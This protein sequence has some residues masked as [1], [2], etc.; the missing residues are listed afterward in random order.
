MNNRIRMSDRQWSA[1]LWLRIKALVGGCITQETDPTV[2][3]WAKQPTKP[4]Y[5]ANEVGAIPATQKG[6]ASGVAELDSGGK[7]PSSQLP[8]YVD[9]VLEY[10]SQS[11]FPA[12]GETGKI[13]VALD[14]NLTYR[15]SGSAYVE[16]SPSL[17][18]GE[19]SST[20]YRG[21]RGKTAYDHAQAH[22]SAF[23]SGLYLIQTNS[24]GH[25]IAAVAVQKSDITALGIPAQDTT[26]SAATQSAAGLMSATDKAKLDGIAAGAQVNSI[27]GV[28]G[29]AEDSYRTGNVNLTAAN[30]GAVPK[31]ADDQIV[32][33]E[34]CVKKV[35]ESGSNNLWDFIYAKSSDEL[36]RVRLMS[37]QT[38]DGAL[39]MVLYGFANGSLQ[40]ASIGVEIDSNNNANYIIGNPAKFRAAASAQLDV[41]F[42]I[43]TQG[44][45]CQRISTDA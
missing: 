30:V 24:E 5:T 23:A 42:Y 4:T 17:A 8:A 32:P 21:D 13:Y 10:A 41:G 27:T 19:T 3:S 31:T 2:P 43:D 15:W 45:L 11:A 12:T 14:T 35:H 38:Q 1:N 29:D 39:K 40:D 20:A 34:W 44:Y 7:V 9:D 16:I 22:G 25:V 36:R 33:Y 28:K 26:Y 37:G 6:A 18:L